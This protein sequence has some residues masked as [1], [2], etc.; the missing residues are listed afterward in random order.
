MKSTDKIASTLRWQN[1]QRE[2]VTQNLNSEKNKVAS[3]E[4]Q[5]KRALVANF[6]KNFPV[7]EKTE[8][9]AS[10]VL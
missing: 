10:H 1:R 6:A 7:P 4:N 9:S 8:Y 2:S 3:A 5:S